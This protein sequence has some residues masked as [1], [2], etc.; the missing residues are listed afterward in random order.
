MK[1]IILLSIFVIPLASLLQM[2]GTIVWYPQYIAVLVMG[3]LFASAL[4]WQKHKALSV[5]SVYCLLSYL[6]V[7]NQHPRAM[8]CLISAYAGIGLICLLSDMKHLR[9]IYRCI[10]AMAIIQFVLVVLQ[11]FNRDPFFHS[12]VNNN[13]SATVGFVGSH[14]Q[15]GSYY[16]AVA[17]IL[18][19]LCLPLAIISFIAIF[20]TKCSTAFIAAV[21]SICAYFIGR[22]PKLA[23]FI[24][25]IVI[26]IPFLWIKIDDARVPFAERWEVWKLS[27]GQLMEGKAKMD[28]GKGMTH[29]VTA[30]PLTGFG[31]G[32]F[33]MISPKTQEKILLP[34][35][36]QKVGHLYEHAHNDI[37]EWFFEGGWI[38]LVILIYILSDILDKFL[39]SPKTKMLVVTFCSLL[40]QGILALGIYVVHAPVSYFMLCLTLGLFYAEARYARQ[41]IQKA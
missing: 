24:I 9:V 13:L 27:A 20:F 29:I 10:V 18:A 33:I 34:F 28:M 14:N 35:Q 8:L 40:A 30:N 41:S 39:F 17:P 3:F 11:I 31:L 15:L 25:P 37:V 26:A 5:L 32:S 1:N 19:G 36:N 16:A 6:F 7:C 12:I 22:K 23:F 4:I 38:G 21:V 2:Q